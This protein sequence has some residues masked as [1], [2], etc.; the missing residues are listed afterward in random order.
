MSAM[1]FHE[2]GSSL[3]ATAAR[4]GFCGRALGMTRPGTMSTL[5]DGRLEAS[6]WPCASRTMPR[7]VG[8]VTRRMTFSCAICAYSAP[9]DDL[10]LEEPHDDD[11]E[12]EE[13]D[14]RHPA[15]PLAELADVGARDEEAL[16]RGLL[17]P[18]ASPTS[19]P[20]GC[21]ARCG[22]RSARRRPSRATCGK[23]HARRARAGTQASR[24]KM[25]SSTRIMMLC[26]S[27]KA[28]ARPTCMSIVCA[29]RR[30][31]AARARM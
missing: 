5:N 8:M 25:A 17:P 20:G 4:I 27:V 6:T 15:V 9:F 1:R 31:P 3:I 18:S 11:A 13:R 10:E 21:A 29:A 19:S 28:S 2:S 26:T 30:T 22:R 7:V 23:R 12:R 16:T 24:P 14:E